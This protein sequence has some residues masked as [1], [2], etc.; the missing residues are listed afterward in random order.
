MENRAQSP[1]GVATR[2]GPMPHF[3]SDTIGWGQAP[4]SDGPAR[5]GAS[6]MF[7]PWGHPLEVAELAGGPMDL[8]AA[9]T[10]GTGSRSAN[11][12]SPLQVHGRGAWRFFGR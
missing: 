2:G 5:G 4:R 7:D 12:D 3:R 9:R 6:V 8:Q 1:D 10:K 11:A